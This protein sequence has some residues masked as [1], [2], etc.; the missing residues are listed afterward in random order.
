MYTFD[1]KCTIGTLFFVKFM[2]RG[3]YF[4]L[5]VLVRT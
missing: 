3:A 5:V 2:D 1:K 4:G